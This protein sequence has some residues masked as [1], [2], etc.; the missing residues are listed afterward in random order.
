MT[1]PM[2]LSV[3]RARRSPVRSPQWNVSIRAGEDF[4][5]ALTVFQNEQGVP[6]N[7]YCCVSQLALIPLDRHWRSCD[8]GLGWASYAGSPA[9]VIK[10][11]GVP[12][13][14]PGRVNFS[15]DSYQ[16]SALFGSYRLV[17]SVDLIDG[18]FIEAEGVF[19][20]RG[21]NRIGLAHHIS[22]FQ[23]DRSQLDGRDMLADTLDATG[24]PID[25]D[26]FQM[27]GDCIVPPIY[28]DPLTGPFS[29]VLNVGVLNQ[30]VLA[31]GTQPFYGNNLPPILNVGILD[32][33]VLPEWP[34]RM[35]M[36]QIFRPGM[37]TP[38]WGASCHDRLLQ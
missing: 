17:I 6:S 2:R 1:A 19:Q 7:T 37:F 34:C 20:V 35:P 18:D 28:N 5:L 38:L 32:Q 10:G 12:E 22:F 29:P 14:G 27:L 8:Y 36:R 31:G 4:K 3:I 16:T 15:M 21:T 13:I 24:V 30:M 26:G 25:E 33:M 11:V 23:L 9:I